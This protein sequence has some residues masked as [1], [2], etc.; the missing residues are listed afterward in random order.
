MCFIKNLCEDVSR[1]FLMNLYAYFNPIV[2]MLYGNS[3][4]DA[5]LAMS[6]PALI[7]KDPK[8]R[9]T[10]RPAVQENA[11]KAATSSDEENEQLVKKS[12]VEVQETTAVP[13]CHGWSP[14]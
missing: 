10:K 4:L 13:T 1:D 14:H 2:Q 9:G 5:L 3:L 11:G 6:I 7:P 8:T 12:R